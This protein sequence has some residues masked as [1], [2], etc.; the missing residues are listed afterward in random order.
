MN[1]PPIIR[2]SLKQHILGWNTCEWWRGKEG[3]ERDECDLVR[4][5]KRWNCINEGFAEASWIINPC[6][7]ENKQHHSQNGGEINPGRYFLFPQIKRRGVLAYKARRVLVPRRRMGNELVARKEQR[8]WIQ[9]TRQVGGR[10]L[11]TL[12]PFGDWVWRRRGE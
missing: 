4:I 12:F 8:F 1:N 9:Q 10:A 7:V 11:P 2:Q 3:E 6:H 5:G